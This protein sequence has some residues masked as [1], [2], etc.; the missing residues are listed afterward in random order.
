MIGASEIIPNLYIGDYIAG[1][2]VYYLTINQFNVVVRCLPS[3]SCHLLYN[4]IDYY[5]IP[6]EDNKSENILKHLPHI[7]RYIDQKLNQGKKILVHCWAGKS[8]SPAIVIAYL[9]YRFNLSYEDA[10]MMVKKKRRIVKPN[11]GFIEQ[12]NTLFIR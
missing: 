6:I 4:G 12:L 8:R 11:S 9:M 1:D 3:P 2:N 5:H 7:I 10:F